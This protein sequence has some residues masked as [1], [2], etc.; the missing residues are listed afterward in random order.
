M[1][2]V[3][4]L[5]QILGWE[6]GQVPKALAELAKRQGLL[7]DAEVESCWMIPALHL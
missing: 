1:Q 2:E 4:E 7:E 3:G 5:D 6:T